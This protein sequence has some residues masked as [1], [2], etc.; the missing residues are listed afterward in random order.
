MP[1]P[2]HAL[3]ASRRP[4]PAR[5]PRPAR[6]PWG[7]LE[8][9]LIAQTVLPALL[10]V[11]GITPVRSLI[12]VAVFGLAMV[13]WATIVL[14]GRSRPGAGTFTALIWLKACAGW[15]LLSILHWNTNS[16]QA[17]LAQAIVYIA[18]FS[19]A[20]WAHSELAS[21][22]QVGRLMMI[23]LACNGLSA[24][25]GLG[26]VFRPGTFNPPVIVGVK[27]E[28][29]DE[30]SISAMSM[31]Y[32]DEHGNKIIRPC[33]LSD[34]SGAASACGATTAL[35]G[36][37]FVLRP[38]GAVRRLASL[39]L[40]FAGMAVIYYSQARVILLMLVICLAVLTLVFVLQRNF[41]HATALGVLGMATVVGALTWVT[42]TSGSVVTKKFLGLLESNLA[43]TYGESRGGFVRNA[44]EVLMWEHPVG[45]GL[46]WWGTIYG[47]FGLKDPSRVLWIEVMWPAWI[48]DG[49][50][51]LLTFYVLAI[52]VAL[53]D[54]LRVALRSRDREVA[55]WAAVVLAS[56]LSAVATCFS[57]V[58]FV[59]PIGIQFWFLA[60]VVHAADRRARDAAASAARA[61]LAARA[62]PASPPGI[63]P[64]A[65]A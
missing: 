64:A 54:S 27:G 26:Q 62:A 14:R 33:G 50:I 61:A 22:R 35:I 47:A 31:T 5:S 16:I 60:A 1:H 20:F 17:G 23:M 55:F 4:S 42:A 45:Y 3:A 39:A 34:Q 58:T 29:I 30:D 40:A 63:P 52:A 59:T 10:F 15:L 11:P 25:V 7:W 46:G 44:F 18:V 13:A 49:G 37:A 6:V 57:Y 38:I 19:P 56:N 41:A 51:P 21:P 36:L 65:P 43:E 9:L 8:W 24:L 12:R 53:A 28:G 2:S 32:E 48:M